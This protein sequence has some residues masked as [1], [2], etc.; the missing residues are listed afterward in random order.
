MKI[1]TEPIKKEE[2]KSMA[3]K[4]FGNLVK[5]VV[6]IEQEIVAVDAEL[7]VDLAELLV[8]RGSTNKNLW[9][10]N[11]YPDETGDNWLEFDSVVNLKPQFN[12]R[13]RGVNDPIIR[14]KITNTLKKY[15]S[16]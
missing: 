7:H 13:T 16:L 1:L 15:V 2:L 12:N 6:D 11:I 3:E 5:A 9:G 14:E 8:E 4:I 10:V